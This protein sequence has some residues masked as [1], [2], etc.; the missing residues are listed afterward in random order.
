[1]TDVQEMGE[2]CPY[3]D[4]YDVCDHLLLSV[5]STFRES[6]GGPLSNAFDDSWALIFDKH[7]EAP[8]YDEY[9]YFQTLLDKV[10]TLADS[11]R[12]FELDLGPGDCIEI[13]NFYIQNFKLI[14]SAVNTFIKLSKSI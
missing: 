8:G 12:D 13:Q 14:N 4:S 6:R 9:S 3:C 7:S 5:N 11:S 2:P 1:M 10:D